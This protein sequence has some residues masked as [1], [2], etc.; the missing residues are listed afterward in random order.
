M[1]DDLLKQ[2]DYWNKTSENFESI[3]TKN[4]NNFLIYLDKVF[5]K[6]MFERFTFT[7]ENCKPVDGKTYLDIGCGTGI[8]SLELAKLGAEKVIGIDIAENMIEIS[9]NEAKRKNMEHKCEFIL[10]DLIEYNPAFEIHISL[11]IGLFDYIKEPLPVVSKMH[12]I[13]EDKA[14]FSFPR[15]FTWRM[16]IRKLRLII[17]RCNVYFYSRKKVKC[18]LEKAGFRKYKIEKIG[19]L[20]CVVG[21]KT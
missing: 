18:L 7:I 12:K 10:S 6:D 8:F 16:P 4:K 19:K 9:K 13:S 2:R 1:R 15:L 17:K 14:I 3:Y 20:F 5:R 11:G 21:Y